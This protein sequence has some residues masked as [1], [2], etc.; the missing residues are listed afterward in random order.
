MLKV[1]LSLALVM[2]GYFGSSRLHTM[3]DPRTTHVSNAQEGA[4]AWIILADLK[5][6]LGATIKERKSPF[7]KVD[8]VKA[9]HLVAQLLRTNGAGK[10]VREALKFLAEVTHWYCGM[11]NAWWPREANAECSTYCG[12]ILFAGFAASIGQ[13]LLI[14]VACMA[15]TVTDQIIDYNIEHLTNEGLQNLLNIIKDTLKDLPNHD[16]S[17]DNELIAHL[18]TCLEAVTSDEDITR[19]WQNLAPEK[20]D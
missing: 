4:P 12:G 6:A 1:L 11:L 19:L 9:A 8:T 14:P 7:F 20:E 16:I 15:S 5:Q 13:L 3:D 2:S 10:E 17:L 18:K